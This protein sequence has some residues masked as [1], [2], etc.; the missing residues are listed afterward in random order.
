MVKMI[1]I[2]TE[3]HG[4]NQLHIDDPLFLVLPPALFLPLCLLATPPSL[5]NG[6]SYNS[7]ACF[8]TDLVYM[9]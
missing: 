3:L 4:Q 5:S 8:L 9:P 6:L 7:G 2:L 1:D